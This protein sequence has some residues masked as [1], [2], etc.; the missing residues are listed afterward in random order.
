MLKLT[1]TQTLFG[2]C[3]VSAALIVFAHFSSAEQTK[4]PA[5]IA[6]SCLKFQT[7]EAQEQFE[8]TGRIPPGTVIGS[9]A[10][11]CEGLTVS[12]IVMNQ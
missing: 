11:P 9:D 6:T 5:R 1:P 2:Y 12:D 7:Y 10:G 4:A 8:E 3:I